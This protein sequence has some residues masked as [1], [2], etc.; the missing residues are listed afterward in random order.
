V[1]QPSL[2]VEKS[3][4]PEPGCI[5]VETHAAGCCCWPIMMRC[6]N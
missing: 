4:L 3:R 2:S 1:R 6:R 5:A